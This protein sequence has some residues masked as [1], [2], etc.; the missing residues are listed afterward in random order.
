MSKNNNNRLPRAKGS[1]MARVVN[2]LL[3]CLDEFECGSIFMA[4]TNLQDE[5]SYSGYRINQPTGVERHWASDQLVH[6]T[7][8]I[9]D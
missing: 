3:H 2:T 7:K 4:A 1:E 5:M 8:R 6:M 9:A